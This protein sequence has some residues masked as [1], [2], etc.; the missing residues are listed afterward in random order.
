VAG[1]QTL[2]N[3]DREIPRRL[4]SIARGPAPLGTQPPHFLE[5]G[6]QALAVD[7]LHGVVVNRLRLAD[8]EDGHNIGMVQLR[9]S[10]CLSAEAFQVGRIHQT[11]KGQ[12][13]ERDVP[14]QR[15]LHR[16]I[17]H[18]HAATPH[19]SQDAVVA[20]SL[21]QNIAFPGFRLKR[22]G[23]WSGHGAEPLHGHEGR[24]QLADLLCQR[25]VPFGVLA[26]GR[27]FAPAIACGKLLGQFFHRIA[28]RTRVS[29]GQ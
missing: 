25:R 20:Q 12:N 16:F 10:P 19:F 1:E 7:K 26:H 3:A 17:D 2:G 14:A 9:C 5:H 22:P 13:L 4:L 23:R 6:I 18:P 24:E 27:M 21:R 11:M 28:C 29:H 15:F 8:A